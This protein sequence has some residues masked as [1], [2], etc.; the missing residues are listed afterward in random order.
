MGEIGE[1]KFGGDG[2]YIKNDWSKIK[3]H[4]HW[5]TRREIWKDKHFFSIIDGKR[6]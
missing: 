4:L 3:T 2:E 6:K 1:R 5:R